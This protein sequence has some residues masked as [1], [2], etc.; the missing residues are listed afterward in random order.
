MA[1]NMT[2]TACGISLHL[3]IWP[4][5]FLNTMH[6]EGQFIKIIFRHIPV[7]LWGH[8]KNWLE[9]GGIYRLFSFLYFSGVMFMNFGNTLLKVRRLSN[10]T[11]KA[12]LMTLSSLCASFFAA[13][14]T[15]SSLI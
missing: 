5:T 4:M 12:I 8:E 1:K 2:A 3:D 14:L 11:E 10:P 15:R 6:G 13:S 7:L 9:A